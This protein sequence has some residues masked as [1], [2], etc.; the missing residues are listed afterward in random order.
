M[1]LMGVAPQRREC[2]KNPQTYYGAQYAFALFY[3][4]SREY[5]WAGWAGDALEQG[6][7]IWLRAMSMVAKE[8]CTSFL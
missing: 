1:A 5:V 8:I 6:G 7:Y 3:R 4:D 2:H